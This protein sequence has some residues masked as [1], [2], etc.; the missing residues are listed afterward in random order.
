MTGTNYFGQGYFGQDYPVNAAVGVSDDPETRVWLYEVWEE[1]A[2]DLFEQFD[3]QIVDDSVEYTF[4]LLEDIQDDAE[5]ADDLL[6]QI[7]EDAQ[8]ADDPETRIALFDD[9][10]TE[11]DQQPELNDQSIDEAPPP[12]DDDSETR[13]L[14][15]DDG[16]EL[17]D[18]DDGLAL[19][20]QPDEESF[21]QALSDPGD[22]PP[23][24]KSPHRGFDLQQWRKERGALDASLEQ[25]IERAWTELTG[26]HQP[27]DIRAE[28][29]R[30]V[31]P[32]V[33]TGSPLWPGEP[34]AFRV[35]WAALGRELVVIQAIAQAQVRAEAYRAA[36]EAD[37]EVITI[38]LLNG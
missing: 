10:S 4:A 3:Q 11:E 16:E 15:F 14:L 34:A 25:T 9:E 24:R 28:A 21:I 13:A 22:K 37:D 26:D 36:L 38:L 32:Y 35:D 29:Q 6:Q 18:D 30:I 1:Y 27:Q 7:I 23:Y 17:G 19:Q 31:V 8:T 2:E 20:E 33:V 12:P 5:W